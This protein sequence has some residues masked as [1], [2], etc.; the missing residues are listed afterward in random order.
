[1][2]DDNRINLHELKA[3]RGARDQGER[4]S[5]TLRV[6]VALAPPCLL[7]SLVLGG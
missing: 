4:A 5:T 6:R 7:D 3:M 2:M 1:M